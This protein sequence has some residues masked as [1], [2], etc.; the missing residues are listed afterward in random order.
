ML[1]ELLKWLPEKDWFD[2]T[3]FILAAIAVMPIAASGGSWCWRR[4]F[5]LRFKTTQQNRRLRYVETR[6]LHAAIARRLRGDLPALLVFTASAN[7]I[8][9]S[10]NVA[11]ALTFLFAVGVF[12]LHYGEAPVV[13]K[14]VL[15]GCYFLSE[16]TGAWLAGFYHGKFHNVLKAV[17]RAA[18]KEDLMKGFE[19]YA[20]KHRL[21]IADA[22]ALLDYAAGQMNH[23][24]F[25]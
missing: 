10:I 4:F 23:F 1:A 17:E 20:T 6:V 21:P 13:F 24:F 5:D 8:Y 7:R 2:W 3:L 11:A 19:E 22:K 25:D 18:S 15:L 14:F 12:F 9:V 16:T